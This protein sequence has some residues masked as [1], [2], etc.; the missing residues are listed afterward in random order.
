MYSI[1][2]ELLSKNC[3]NIWIVL[4]LAFLALPSASAD[5][6]LWVGFNTQSPI[7]KYSTTGVSAGSFGPNGA[8]GVAL[9]GSGTVFVAQ[10]TATDTKISALDAA[11]NL[12]FSFDFTTG[13]DPDATGFGSWV[14]D[15]TYG[16]S[17]TLWIAA[18]TGWVYQVNF[19]GAI[20]QSFNTTHQS[21]GVATNGSVLYTTQGRDT[22]D[23]DV[24][25]LGGVHSA[26]IFTQLFEGGG[27]GHAA[28]DNTLWVGA[29]TDVYHVS[30]TGTTLA[31]LTLSPDAFHD[32]LE[33]G[34][35]GL[36]AELVPEPNSV[37]TAVI[38]ACMIAAL[39]YFRRRCSSR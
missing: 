4:F 39:A 25:T 38:G 11:Q 1:C 18:F 13:V 34:S 31:K 20:I 23:I 5:E 10:P 36:Q 24:W 26:T 28:S 17:N 7:Q 2:R 14:D 21:T 9:D 35:V 12:L 6:L 15:M 16:G 30:L 27:I 33:V 32:G 8:S 19:T 3:R 37:S 29:S 22:G